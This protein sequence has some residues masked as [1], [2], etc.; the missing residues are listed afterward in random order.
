[1]NIP[2]VEITMTHAKLG[3]NMSRPPLEIK[4]R[5]ADIH[6]EQNFQHTV[7]ISTE[8]ASVKIDQSEAFADANM[9]HPFDRLKQYAEKGKQAAL[10][11]AAKKRVKANG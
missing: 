7:H 3:M 8:S 9:I 5:P 2:M 11:Y 1:M 10:E 4:Q 6:I